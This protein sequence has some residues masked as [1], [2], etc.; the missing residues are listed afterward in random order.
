MYVG[1]RKYLEFDFLKTCLSEN[2]LGLNRQA[3]F[4]QI[5]FFLMKQRYPILPKETQNGMVWSFDSKMTS[6]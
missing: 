1:V 6:L 4:M 5:T 2:L 3:L